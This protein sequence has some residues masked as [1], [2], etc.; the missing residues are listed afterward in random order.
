MV[1]ARERLGWCGHGVYFQCVTSS[2]WSS[3]LAG[4]KRQLVASRVVVMLDSRTNRSLWTSF[5]EEL[6]STRFAS[7]GEFEILRLYGACAVVHK[8]QVNSLVLY[9]GR[10]AYKNTEPKESVMSW[11][12]NG[13]WTTPPGLLKRRQIISSNP[14]LLFYPRCF[15]NNIH[16][17]FFSVNFVQ[18]QSVAWN[19]LNMFRTPLNYLMLKI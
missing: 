13:G 9:T 2:M 18:R 11:F 14:I 5:K 7:E 12:T 6:N 19:L 1:P 16:G 3:S 17:G 4:E 8:S 15:P 10:V